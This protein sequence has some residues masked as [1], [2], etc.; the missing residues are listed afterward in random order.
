MQWFIYSF[1]FEQW[2]G[3]LDEFHVSW[4]H[5]RL[6][7]IEWM[8]YEHIACTWYEKKKNTN[9]TK[10]IEIMKFHQKV[11][12]KIPSFQ[13]YQQKHLQWS[14]SELPFWIFYTAIE[15]NLWTIQQI[16]LKLDLDFKIRS[17]NFV[18]FF[19]EIKPKH[20]FSLLNN[21][22]EFIQIRLGLL[23]FLCFAGFFASMRLHNKIHNS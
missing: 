13:S 7:S 17:K 22:D 10:F 1:C 5:V 19:W 4:L 12:K 23:Y 11:T 18:F 3:S 9:T 14:H 15:A 6:Y 8:W 16:A 20:Q 21:Y 2:L